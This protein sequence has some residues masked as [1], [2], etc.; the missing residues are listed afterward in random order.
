MSGRKDHHDR[1][2]GRAEPTLG[3]LG[4]L[5][6]PHTHVHDPDDRLPP[7]SFETPQRPPPARH[8]R[9]RV[10]SWH[11][12][13][14]VVVL[15]VGG[16][17]WALREYQ[18][19]LRDMVP[20]TELN[21]VLSRADAALRDGHLDGTDGS[22]ARELY[23]SA[24]GL[25]PDND[26]ARDGLHQV[27]MAEL[28]RADTAYR[29]GRLDEAR[30][31][32]TVAR[33]LLGGGNDVDRLDSKIKQA[34][35]AAEP[36]DGLV[37]R[38]QQALAAGK[39]TGDDGAGALYQHVLAGDPD[40]AVARHGLDQVGAGL[41]NQAR[42][43]LAH[44]DPNT[45]S[46]R[47]DQLAAMLPSYG[48]LPSL[49]AALAQAQQQDQG[50][51]L[52]AISQGQ[53]AL[54]D[55]RISGAG[56]NTALAHFQHALELDPTDPQAR[57]GLGQVARALVV[58]ANA[59]LD[60][61]DTAQA[62]NL[63][64]QAAALAPKSADLA[65]TRARLA[66]AIA[67]AAPQTPAQPAPTPAQP[68]QEVEPPPPPPPALTVDQIEQ[69][70]ELV[71]RARTAASQGQIMLPPGDSA[72]DLYRN[73]LAIDGNNR[74]A[75]QGLEDLPNL[76]VQLFNQALS[77]GNLGK[78]GELLGALGDLSP[79]DANASVLRGRLVDAW[80]DLAEQQLD[81]GDRANAAQSIE[82]ARKLAPYQSRVTELS[83]RLQ[84][85]R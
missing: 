23:Q 2:N 7:I 85:G 39:L 58:Q 33:E 66:S 67:K 9:V 34:R 82:Q 73:A 24:R 59:A 28:S 57:A 53:Q 20:R 52:E 13:L 62:S 84:S 56:N 21:D 45:A 72:Y 49:R 77:G 25:E 80:L 31:E 22:S 26:R 60:A 65:A 4:G 27:G 44:D 5:D 8:R 35:G 15:V 64:D 71:R 37:E 41:A 38:A 17:V 6:T 46:A 40:N 83:L 42:A 69:V 74:A 63:L 51:L 79:G 54:R 78:A 81:R 14:L 61:D 11:V 18:N 3:D 48:E 75:L 36:A 16:G 19:S 29:A 76:V 50:A 1:R 70:A 55:G 47:I 68:A 10:R 43:A 32:L 30:R 12:V